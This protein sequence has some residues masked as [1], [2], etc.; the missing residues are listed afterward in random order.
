MPIGF[1]Q[2]AGF[3]SQGGIGERFRKIAIRSDNY[4]D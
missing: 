2:P 3:V 1:I 4:S